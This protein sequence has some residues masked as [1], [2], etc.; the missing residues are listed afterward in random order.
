MTKPLVEM[1]VIDYDEDV[2]SVRQEGRLN[3]DLSAS[4]DRRNK[5]S[6]DGRSRVANAT[7]SR[8]SLHTKTR[9]Y[10]GKLVAT[11][12]KSVDLVP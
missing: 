9:I 3:I 12:A 4:V 6:E 8:G 10:N 1:R 11:E 2:R 7:S 5:L